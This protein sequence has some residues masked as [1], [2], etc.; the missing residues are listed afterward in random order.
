MLLRPP[1]AQSA[2]VEADALGPRPRCS[3]RRPG[4][5]RGNDDEALGHGL[6]HRPQLLLVGSQRLVGS[7]ALGG[8]RGE[9]E[10]WS[11]PRR[12]GTAGSRGGCRC[13]TRGT[14]GPALCAVFQTVSDET[15]TSA[16]AAPRG[17]NAQRAQM[18]TGKTTYGTK[19]CDGSSATQEGGQHRGPLEQVPAREPAHS[20]GRPGE[21]QRGDHQRA[22]Q[23]PPAPARPRRTGCLEHVPQAQSPWPRSLCSS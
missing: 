12:P 14:N 11:A 15:T 9:H 10:R 17:P 16:V 20:A 13:S 23:P 7:S 3:R 19:R 8:H 6:H 2:A 18:S 21:D 22:R 4:V 5:R 1:A